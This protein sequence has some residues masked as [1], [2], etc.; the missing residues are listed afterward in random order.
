MNNEEERIV[1]DKETRLYF[2]RT[3][4]LN[5]EEET[6]VSDKETHNFPI[7]TPSYDDSSAGRPSSDRN[8]TEETAI[9]DEEEE[10]TSQRPLSLF[11]LLQVVGIFIITAG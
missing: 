6:A 9:G 5:N 8:D 4:N 11:L 2:R 3:K 1:S 10:T 7:S